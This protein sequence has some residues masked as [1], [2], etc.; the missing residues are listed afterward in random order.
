MRL[1]PTPTALLTAFVLLLASTAGAE[2]I[3]PLVDFHNNDS[4]WDAV[5]T[6][7][8]YSGIVVE[9]VTSSHVL[10]EIAKTFYE[11]PIQGLF[12]SNVIGFR[13]R[14]ADAQTVGTI[15]IKDEIITNITGEP[16]TDYHWQI[17]GSVAAFDSG[18]T[19]G[20]GFD[21]APF[22]TL[23]W[24][25]AQTGWDSAHPASLDALDGT[26]PNGSVFIPGIAGGNLF[27]EVDLAGGN[28]EF[29]LE[30]YPT[31]EPASLAILATGAVGMLLRR[32]HR[33]S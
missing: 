17:V 7:N 21:A 26:V 10:I 5:L 31:P 16:W 23:T 25:P 6:D 11:G 28:A 24:G 1:P 2:V 9:E 27:I 8:I 22:T 18:A 32:R 33:R 30:Q 19:D 12:P 15:R 13:Q 3:V 29:A 14:L 4:G 20:S